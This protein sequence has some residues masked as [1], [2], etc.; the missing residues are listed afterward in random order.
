MGGGRRATVAV[1]PPLTKPGRRRRTRA[2]RYQTDEQVGLCLFYRARTG[3][4]CGCFQKVNVV[5][6]FC[7]L[8]F[9]IYFLL[10]FFFSFFLLPMHENKCCSS[11]G[12]ARLFGCL[13][14]C[15]VCAFY[16]SHLLGG[17]V[18]QRYNHHHHRC[19]RIAKEAAFPS[20]SSSGISSRHGLFLSFSISP[21]S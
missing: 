17:G 20:L 18:R 6:L 13:F 1:N 8:A 19:R 9:F 3:N 21:A 14:F 16:L 5:G 12:G 4:C 2:A 15:L 10:F 11:F 7:V